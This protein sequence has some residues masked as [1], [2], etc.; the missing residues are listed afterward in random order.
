M[1]TSSSH[2]ALFAPGHRQDSQ[3]GQHAEGS[4]AF[5]DRA[6]HS[7][8]PEV[9]HVLEA[10]YSQYPDE[11]KRHLASR[12]R[13]RRADA[14]TGAWWELYLFTLMRNLGYEVSIL[15]IAGA[16]EPDFLVETPTESFYLEATAFSSGIVDESHDARRQGPMLDLI[17]E[18]RSEAFLLAVEFKC[19][20][21]TTPARSEVLEPIEAWLAGLDSALS[22]SGCENGAE[23]YILRVR[24]WEIE[25]TPLP[26]RNEEN[27]PRERAIGLYPPVVGWVNDKEQARKALRRKAKQHPRS[28]QPLVVALLS[29]S[30]FFDAEEVGNA[31]FGS[32]AFS[33]TPGRPDTKGQWV[34]QRDGFWI[35]EAGPL[36]QHVAGVLH[37]DGLT[38][39]TVVSELPR[40][41]RNPWAD[42]VLGWNPPLPTGSSSTAGHVTVAET[43]LSPHSVLSLDEGWPDFERRAQA[44][45]RV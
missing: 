2:R 24:D 9:R 20:G 6:A 44:A 11:G 39:R 27:E 40:L 26:A 29:N 1:S 14:H 23:P 42:P 8:W 32:L 4:F 33:F 7:P 3:P 22:P 45:L 5:L 38:P 12:F 16:S 34:R 31:L 15:D 17:N 10:W 19:V 43:E 37:A 25:L 21:N 18:V 30:T 41:W 36:A 28:D 35:D 13:S